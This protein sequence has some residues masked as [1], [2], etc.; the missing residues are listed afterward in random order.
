MN[1]TTLPA[2][3]YWLGDPCYVVG[4]PYEKWHDLVAVFYGKDKNVP[5]TEIRVVELD[6]QKMV[7]SGTNYGDGVDIGEQ[8]DSVMV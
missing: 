4:K 6:G 2:G 8:M 7:W 3:T 1:K 5:H